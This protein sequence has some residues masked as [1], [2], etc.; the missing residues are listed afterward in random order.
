MFKVKNQKG[1]TLVEL[2][3]VVAIIGIL[4]AVAIPQFQTYQA[5]S[6]TSEAKLSLAGVYSAQIAFQG[7]TGFYGTCLPLMGFLPTGARDANN[8]NIIAAT[9]D[10]PAARNYNIGYTAAAPGI[11]IAA[12]RTVVPQ[13]DA[14]A[15]DGAREM[16]FSGSKG[17]NAAGAPIAGANPA[18]WVAAGT[19][20]EGQ[21]TAL[22]SGRVISDFAANTDRW[23]M[24]EAKQLVHTQ[25]GY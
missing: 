12:I 14:A 17:G 23:A 7:E 9:E 22:A 4:S 1:F 18:G 19:V 15:S 11:N 24:N 21:F 13:C 3:V 20:T 25:I 2:M 16:F 5:K 10:T 8:N 6:R